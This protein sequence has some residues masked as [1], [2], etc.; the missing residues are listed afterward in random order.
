MQS[1]SPSMMQ[2]PAVLLMMPP[3]LMFAFAFGV[4]AAI[5]RFMPLPPAAV[6]GEAFWAGGALLAAG[7]CVGLSLAARFLTRRTTLN[8]FAN[9]AEMVVTGPYGLSRNPMYLTLIVA[10]LGGTLML[11]SVWPLVTLA[12]PVAILTRVVIPFEEVR[13]LAVFG[14]RYRDYQARVRRWL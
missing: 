3:P 1:Q 4:G 11:G 7:V 14:G 13:M 2:K 10:Y 12:V 5:H 9:P 6:A 8:P